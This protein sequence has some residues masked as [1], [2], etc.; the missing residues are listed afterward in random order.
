MKKLFIALSILVFSNNA[1]SQVI[2]DELNGSTLGT[3]TG[4]TYTSTPNG[5]GAVLSRSTESRIEYPFEM[6]LHIH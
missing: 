6:G 5:Q 4:I 3:A 2:L 1:D